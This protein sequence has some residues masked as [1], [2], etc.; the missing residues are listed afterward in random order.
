M[1]ATFLEA[2]RAE[3]AA[4]KRKIGIVEA[5]LAEYGEPVRSDDAPTQRPKT[6]PAKSINSRSADSFSEYGESV[7]AAAVSVLQES[8]GEP[9]P[10]RDLVPM[11]ERSGVA[12]RGSNKQNALSALLSRSSAVQSNGRKGWTLTA[13]RD[14]GESR[15]ENAPTNDFDAILGAD[16]GNGNAATFPKPWETTQ[17]VHGG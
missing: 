5:M 6:P 17:S 8:F 13:A 9:I 14:D 16:A 3:L 1:D 4:L 7:I 12:I 10:T 2:A 11:I 15:K